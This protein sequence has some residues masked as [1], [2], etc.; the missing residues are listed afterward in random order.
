MDEQIEQRVEED[1]HNGTKLLQDPGAPS[2]RGSALRGLGK[3]CRRLLQDEDWDPLSFRSFPFVSSEPDS[4]VRI[5]GANRDM[6]YV[7]VNSLAYVNY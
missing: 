7:L 4:Q 3:S 1:T 5:I 6:Y 2:F